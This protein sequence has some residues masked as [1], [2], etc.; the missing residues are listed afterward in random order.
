MVKLRSISR[1]RVHYVVGDY[2]QYRDTPGP[3]RALINFKLASSLVLPRC[4]F[5]PLSLSLNRNFRSSH[6]RI[7]LPAAVADTKKLF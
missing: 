7:Y 3:G 6:Y 2:D 1:S 5:G 4:A